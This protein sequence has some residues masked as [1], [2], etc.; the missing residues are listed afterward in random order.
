MVQGV[1]AGSQAEE[2]ANAML[3]I[4][5]PVANGLAFANCTDGRSQ[6]GEAQ[7]EVFN[8][9]IVELALIAAAG[10]DPP[11][12]T[13]PGP[14]ATDAI[15]GTGREGDWVRGIGR[16][17]GSCTSPQPA[18][19]VMADGFNA[20]GRQPASQD[21][22]HDG[23]DDSRHAGG[24]H[25]DGVIRVRRVAETAAEVLRLL[26]Q[27]G[28]LSGSEALAL[29]GQAVAELLYP[30]RPGLA[31]SWAL[32]Y[33]HECF[34]TGF[35]DAEPRQGG[36][37]AS[38]HTGFGHA[39]HPTSHIDRQRPR[40]QQ[41]QQ[42]RRGQP[43]AAAAAAAAPHLLA[44]LG[45][46]LLVGTAEELLQH[47]AAGANGRPGPNAAS[48][49][50]PCPVAHLLGA[51][52]AL[53]GEGSAAVWALLGR[54]LGSALGEPQAKS[55]EPATHVPHASSLAA[56]G[57]YEKLLRAERAMLQAR[58]GH[59]ATAAV[60]AAPGGSN[61]GGAKAADF[62]EQ[63]NLAL[64]VVHSRRQHLAAGQEHGAG[65]GGAA[66]AVAPAPA[67]AAATGDVKLAG[68]CLAEFVKQG[69]AHV[70]KMAGPFHR[71]NWQQRVKPVLLRPTLD[72]VAAR[73]IH[74]YLTACANFRLV[75]VTDLDRWEQLQARLRVDMDGKPGAPE[76]ASPTPFR[77]VVGFLR[78]LAEVGP[79]LEAP[80]L[81]ELMAQLG[82]ALA[83]EL[84][85]AAAEDAV[86]QP[87]S[88]AHARPSGALP[89]GTELASAPSSGGAA[90]R[91][92]AEELVEMVLQAFVA[93][94]ELGA[95]AAAPPQPRP[96]DRAPAAPPLA[97]LPASAHLGWQLALLDVVARTPPLHEP[98]GRR[99]LQLATDPGISS[100][101]DEG[102][103]LGLAAVLACASA[104]RLPLCVAATGTAVDEFMKAEARYMWRLPPP[105]ACLA[106]TSAAT[107]K[108][109]AAPTPTMA[110]PG[111]ALALATLG[112]LPLGPS[113]RQVRFS[114]TLLVAFL[115]HCA[116]LGRWVLFGKAP[117]QHTQLQ[118]AA[119]PTWPEPLPFSV[120]GAGEASAPP[121]QAAAAPWAAQRRRQEAAG[122]VPVA[123]LQTLLWIERYAAAFAPAAPARRGGGCAGTGDS[124]RS[125]GTAGNGDKEEAD[126]ED[127]ACWLDVARVC[128]AFRSS[129]LGAALLAQLEESGQ[130]RLGGRNHGIMGAVC[131]GGPG[132]CGS[133]VAERGG[134]GGGG[135]CAQ[136]DGWDASAATR[137]AERALRQGLGM[138]PQ[139]VR[140]QAALLARCLAAAAPQSEGAAGA[141][142]KGA[143]QV[144]TG[145]EQGDWRGAEKR[146]AELSQGER[147]AAA[148]VL[149]M[150]RARAM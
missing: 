67:A 68:E 71:A 81:A 36:H 30:I 15:D 93:A 144:A 111:S 34:G 22:H 83:E 63:L 51:V 98:L 37:D 130:L 54:A 87:G 139:L 77:P 79:S 142:A 1:L 108:P 35:Q 135:R 140:E 106:G 65:R 97:P 113:P 17:P 131:F 117:E 96:S 84:R 43:G 25:D 32:T 4:A 115:R 99:L 18:H 62:L 118:L 31:C 86:S 76:A 16:H 50:Q 20:S 126:E 46:P 38:L 40:Q 91:E 94:E 73:R 6:A 42:Q 8:T 9:L 27:K 19:D 148:G 48:A 143:G 53:G 103:V 95:A 5:C 134:G 124:R 60:A 132:G 149:V 7:R 122:S 74:K 49:W 116:A 61:G 24:G 107:G 66:V 41:Q 72:A 121:L 11:V 90:Q 146:S 141:A 39:A 119:G 23:D 45:L 80:T 104:V 125:G 52:A 70:Q 56:L 100:A 127:G 147:S 28:L 75:T 110:V 102:Q 13:E 78:Q 120:S 29:M 10:E 145:G 128:L 59:G 101:L 2:L 3:D 33:T 82:G 26:L 21:G 12:P 133:G 64:A 88:M 89:P 150:K 47:Q 92:V 136:P 14:G 114:A 58:P 105:S 138:P 137:L 44:V 129:S 69:E 57:C 123:A 112:A 109:A 85:A 55:A